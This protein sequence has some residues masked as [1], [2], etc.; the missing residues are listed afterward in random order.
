MKH[1]PI[2]LYLL[3]MQSSIERIL[4]Y[5]RDLNIEEFSK[6]FMVIDAVVRNFE[7]LGEAAKHIPKP[8]REEYPEVPWKKMYAMR[9]MVIHE[10]FGVDHELIWDIIVNHLPGNLKDLKEVVEKFQSK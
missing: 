4:E 7:V 3:D 2:L 9:N 6:N 8:I 5:T 1:R 10:Y